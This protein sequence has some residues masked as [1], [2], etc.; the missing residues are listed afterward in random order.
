MDHVVDKPL[1]SPHGVSKQKINAFRTDFLKNKKNRLAQNAALR[2]ELKQVT[3]NADRFMSI[4]HNFSDVIPDELKVT[5]QLKSGRCWLFAALN[6]LRYG[7]SQKLKLEEFEFSQNYLFF[8]DKFE[9]SNYFLENIIATAH[10]PFDSRLVSH[11]LSHPVQD[12]GQWHMF[13]NLVD[14]YGLVPKSAF[15]D[16]QGCADSLQMN[17]LITLKLRDS[18]V[19][20]R[21]MVSKKKAVKEL[22]ATK[23]Q[24]LLEIFRILCIHLGTP[25]T[26]INWE[27]RNKDKKFISEYD[28][29][30]IEF[31]KKYNLFKLDS[32]IALVHSPRKL[33]P[34]HKTYTVD[35]LNNTIEGHPILYLNVSP[36]EMK[37]AVINSIKAKEPVWFGCDV[38]QSFHRDLGV[39]DHALYDLDLMYDFAITM[40]KA[41]RMNYGES[42][43]THAMLFTGVNIVNGKPTKWRVENSWGKDVGKNGYFI[44]TDEWFDEYMFEVA[45]NPKYLPK[46]LIE[47]NKLKP[48]HLPPWDP[49]GALA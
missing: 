42:Q 47:L 41:D 43:M 20:L 29:T 38:G 25:P 18:A 28:I 10:E 22:E 17:K 5:S 6:L 27:E 30:P 3:M 46:Q 12:G 36:K 16:T 32:Y 15:P 44:M 31:A 34:L 45:I 9:K 24:M 11:L 40:N 14:K 8:W 19:I 23:E 39:M 13:V 21:E 2:S 49:M 33:T 26:E 7:I 35:Y 4:N 37:T 1:K 48:L